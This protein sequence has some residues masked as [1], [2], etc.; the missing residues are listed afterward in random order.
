MAKLTRPVEVRARLREALQLDLIGPWAGHPLENERL[1]G[2]ERPSNWYLTGFL[3]PRGAP[4]KQRADADADDDFEA[5]VKEKAGLGDDS[6]E[7]RRAAKRGFFPSS[8]GLSFLVGEAVESLEVTVRWG[9]YRLVSAGAQ[10]ENGHGP[11]PR[12][13]GRRRGEAPGDSSVQ[14]W[15][16]RTP[17]EEV[18]AMV[19]PAAEHPHS[20]D[21]PR[22]R[23]ADAPFGGTAGRHREFFRSY[24]P[25]T[26]SVSLFLVN[27]RSVATDGARDESFAFQ[28]E[29][30]V[31]SETPFVPRPDPRSASGDDWDEYVADL[32]YGDV[33]EYA[34]GHGVAADWDLDEDGACHRLRTTWTPV[35]EVE[36]TETVEVPGVELDMAE[37]GKL[38]DGEAA[39]RALTPLVTGYRSWIDEQ[40]AALT[41]LKGER[42]ETA[43]ELL[44]HAGFAANR[45]ERGIRVLAQDGDALDA[46]RMANRAVASALSRRLSRE[47][48]AR[49]PSLARIPV[50]VPP[51]EPRRHYGPRESRARIRRPALLP[52]RRRQDRGLSRARRVHLGVAAAAQ[53]GR[54]WAGRSRGQ[55]HH[56]VHV[57]AVDAG[58]A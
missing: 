46:F 23:R 25:G 37:L 3:V 12:R 43:G 33:P 10:A 8:M 39:E 14:E 24:P 58:P 11:S 54:R 49:V 34:A 4:F 45:M 5:E 40:R 35:A 9:D 56:A 28:A 27:E 15:W 29:I 6:I 19:L 48:V 52:H 16:Q 53:P 41:A 31:R 32:H 36:K 47:G 44:R 50:G 17:R 1:R 51:V 20:R 26:R 57:A 13:D 21:G 7:E 22:L 18:V 2:W 55:R 42:R 30:E 38:A